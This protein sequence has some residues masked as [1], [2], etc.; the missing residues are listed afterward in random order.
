MQVRRIAW[1][2]ARLVTDAKATRRRLAGA[3]IEVRR[4]HI[5]SR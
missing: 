4:S 1:P 3:E 5:V 2:S